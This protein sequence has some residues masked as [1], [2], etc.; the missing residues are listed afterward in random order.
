M[1]LRGTRSSAVGAGGGSSQLE[2]HIFLYGSAP[3]AS[4]NGRKLVSIQPPRSQQQLH[5]RRKLSDKS[6]KEGDDDDDFVSPPTSVTANSKNEK[7]TPENS[8]KNDVETTVTVDNTKGKLDISNENVPEG[9]TATKEVEKETNNVDFDTKKQQE[10]SEN[11][12][13]K[14]QGG[15]A[16]TSEEPQAITLDV[17]QDEEKVTASSLSSA[18]SSQQQQSMLDF[19]NFTDVWGEDTPAQNENEGGE[20]TIEAKAKT[21]QQ[22][23]EETEEKDE[24]EE[25][26]IEAIEEEILEIKE[27]LEELSNVDNIKQ[28]KEDLVKELEGKLTID[29]EKEIQLL[30][31]DK[32]KKKKKNMKEEE[33]EPNKEE[34]EEVV[35]EEVEGGEEKNTVKTEEGGTGENGVEEETEKLTFKEPDE[36]DAVI[37]EE[38]EEE[39]A[40]PTKVGMKD[41]LEG[42]AENDEQEILE[43]ET[44]NELVETRVEKSTGDNDTVEIK[45]EEEIATSAEVVSSNTKVGGCQDDPDFLYKGYEGFNCE[46]IKENKPEKCNKMHDGKKVGVVSCPVSCDM[47]NECMALLTTTEPSDV[48]Q[49][50]NDVAKVTEPEDEAPVETPPA[51]ATKD[52]LVVEEKEEQQLEKEMDSKLENALEERTVDE[53][54]AEKLEVETEQATEENVSEKELEEE[55]D[56]S[57]GGTSAQQVGDEADDDPLITIGLSHNEE[58][59]MIELDDPPVVANLNINADDLSFC[60]DDAEFKFKGLEGFNCD[61]IKENKPEKC[62]KIHNGEKVGVVSC[63]VSCDMVN[64]CMALQESKVDAALANASLVEDSVVTEETAEESSEVNEELVKEQESTMDAEDDEKK[65]P[66]VTEEEDNVADESQIIEEINGDED[67]LAASVDETSAAEVKVEEDISPGADDETEENEISAV[68]DSQIDQQSEEAATTLVPTQVENE[69]EAI[70]DQ[71]LEKE[72]EAKL[73]KALEGGELDEEEVEELEYEMEE[74]LEE[75]AGDLFEAELDKELRCKDD[76]N[77]LYFVDDLER[78]C[79]WIRQN[80]RCQ[81]VHEDSGKVIG[82]FF[83]PETC[84]MKE[85]CEMLTAVDNTNS[86]QMP[87]AKED[88]DTFE[89]IPKTTK[90]MADEIEFENEFDEKPSSNA[91][92][93][94]FDEKPSSNAYGTENAEQNLGGE[95]SY[96]DD[97]VDPYRNKEED[98][99]F[100]EYDETTK[101]ENLNQW[102]NNMGGSKS[103]EYYQEPNSYSQPTNDIDNNWQGYGGEDQQN[104]NFDNN[105]SVDYDENWL[106]DDG[107]FPFGI[108]VLLFLGVGFF[109]FRKS[110]SSSSRRQQDMSRG[111]YQR[112]GHRVDLQEHSKRY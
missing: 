6:W 65:T 41:E 99:T 95:D 17:V 30:K 51:A 33:E 10:K 55:L 37:V 42:S 24:D 45:E 86:L 82:K 67:S 54:T 2:K 62:N 100:N 79:L 16:T 109:I 90:S 110:Q 66:E 39:V 19:S 34:K 102:D 69:E 35:E 73:E 92:E 59:S 3:S 27:T 77:F 72:I 96:V 56:E 7:K 84:G 47:V 53:D 22:D 28:E 107:G 9:I 5:G 46:Y 97:K 23:T 87:Q 83:C 101:T 88:D 8:E 80:Q 64:E 18:S 68:I 61:Y 103:Q 29:E 26:A 74:A 60:L 43:K 106:D 14:T 81:H 36:D 4:T 91:Y 57:T 48:V 58:A 52:E 108:M 70:D 63:P 78:D 44:E 11:A 111:S 49:E 105:P 31:M 32:K 38:K 104:G 112:V 76:P 40:A 98:V 94:E 1:S 75:N 20:A 15:T 93:N 71:Q 85:E 13:K 21:V 25:E 12:S 89:A 50:A